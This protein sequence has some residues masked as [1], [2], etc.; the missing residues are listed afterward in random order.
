MLQETST[1]RRWRAR[2]PSAIPANPTFKPYLR[3]AP[4]RDVARARPALEQPLDGQPRKD[5][6]GHARGD[7]RPGLR[8]VAHQLSV[9]ALDPVQRAVIGKPRLVGHGGHPLAEDGVDPA[10]KRATVDEQAHL[11]VELGRA[12]VEV[13][14]AD[15]DALAVHGEGLRVKTGG[16][17]PRAS[18][19]PGLP[20][21]GGL[22]LGLSPG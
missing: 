12:R 3:G 2:E 18:D 6:N 8:V 10:R 7:A 13:V 17:A 9:A 19:E 21:L 14:R 15:E 5:P 20:P 16:G 1:D 22:P 11:R 4:A